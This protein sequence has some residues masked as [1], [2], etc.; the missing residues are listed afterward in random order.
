M[1][2]QMKRA[3]SLCCAVALLLGCASQATPSATSLTATIPEGIPDRED[4]AWLISAMFRP[5]DSCMFDA[6]TTERLGSNQ[7]AICDLS[8]S[9]VRLVQEWPLHPGSVEVRV[10]SR[11]HQSESSVVLSHATG[12]WLVDSVWIIDA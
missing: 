3:L 4:L 1:L 6:L 11:R 8:G 12:K 10:R 5:N 9:V 7:Q 2:R